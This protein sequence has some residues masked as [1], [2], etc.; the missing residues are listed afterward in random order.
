[1]EGHATLPFMREVL[2]FLAAA[3]LIVPLISRLKVSP[4]LGYLL[5]GSLVGPFGLGRLAAHFPMLADFVVADVDGVRRL[6]EIGVI[7]LMF[8]IGLELSLDRL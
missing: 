6:A 7:F 4:V 2:I 3:G 1:M 5:I 8:M